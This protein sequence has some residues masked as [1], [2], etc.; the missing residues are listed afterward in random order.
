MSD[1]RAGH[2]LLSAD[3]RMVPAA[4]IDQIEVRGTAPMPF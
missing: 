2:T 4:E 3:P 1:E